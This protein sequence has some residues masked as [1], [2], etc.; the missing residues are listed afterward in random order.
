MKHKIDIKS[1]ALGAILSAVVMFSIAATT[2][3]S[4]W[5]YKIISGKVTFSTPGDPLLG[6][7]LDQAAAEG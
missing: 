1:L 6:K 2:G 3:T 7:Q 5:E 4:A